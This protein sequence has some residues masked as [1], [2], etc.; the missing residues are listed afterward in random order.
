MINHWIHNKQVHDTFLSSPCFQTLRP[1]KC[2][3][4]TGK[5]KQQLCLNGSQDPEHDKQNTG[6]MFFFVVTSLSPHYSGYCY[7]SD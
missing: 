3:Q 4:V 7:Y 2:L 6:N 1:R 5:K